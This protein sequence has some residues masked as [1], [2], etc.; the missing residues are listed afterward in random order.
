[1]TAAC[2]E[3][4]SILERQADDRLQRLK[5]YFSMFGD[6]YDIEI[7]DAVARHDSVALCISVGIYEDKMSRIL[8]EL[9][10]N[11]PLLHRG[12]I[13]YQ[14]QWVGE[15][16]NRWYTAAYSYR[17]YGELMLMHPTVVLLYHPE[18]RV[19]KFRKNVGSTKLLYAQ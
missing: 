6:T 3:I 18:G 10:R 14:G 13:H 16:I 12:S 17:P 1:M 7:T 2:Y 5:G 19:M 15:R 8:D 4:E 11:N 9:C